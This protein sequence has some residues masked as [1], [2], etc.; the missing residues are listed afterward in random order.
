MPAERIKKSSS[1][2]HRKWEQDLERE[3]EGVQAAADS[4][5]K[6]EGVKTPTVK[7]IDAHFESLGNRLQEIR[8]LFNNLKSNENI[9]HIPRT[10]LSG[11][12]N[13]FIELTEQIDRTKTWDVDEKRTYIRNNEQPPFEWELNSLRDMV[14]RYEDILNK[15]K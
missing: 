11:V 4:K 14:N 3:A 13:I 8:Q 1:E 7:L 12:E 5:S 6:Q 9:D 2:E 15:Q 10:E